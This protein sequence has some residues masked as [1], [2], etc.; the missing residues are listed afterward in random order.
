VAKGVSWKEKE[1]VHGRLPFNRRQKKE[2][3][4]G[5]ERGRASNEGSEKKSVPL[6]D[7][8]SVGESWADKTTPIPEVQGPRRRE[9]PQS[10][11]LL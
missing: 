1:E 4:G 9:R 8:G 6:R 2:Q 7:L 3:K 10:D 5:V 11:V